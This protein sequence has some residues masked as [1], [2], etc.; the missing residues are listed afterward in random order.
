MLRIICLLVTTFWLLATGISQAEVLQGVNYLA[1][2]KDVK[3]IYPNA[4]YTKLTPAW[5]KEDEAFISVYGTGMA[6][7]IYIL[8]IDS[9]PYLR[10]K[11]V[12]S[13]DS[14]KTELLMKLAKE[15]DDTALTVDWVRWIPDSPIPIERFQSRYGK[16]KCDF[17]EDMSP[18]CTWRER[19]LTASMTGD[20]KNVLHV[21]TG[22]TKAEKQS[23]ATVG[24]GFVPEYL[25]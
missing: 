13:T 6:G 4:T 5:L 2:L 23:G 11:V 19:A 10:K 18:I 9:R 1:S 17:D 20:N 3:N 7:K 16:P 24:L 25:K 8:F 21:T 22:F 15:P 12:E 14:S